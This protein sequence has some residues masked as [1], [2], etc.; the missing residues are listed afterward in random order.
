MMFTK[1]WSA[2]TAVE[3][4]DQMWTGRTEAMYSREQKRKA[5]ETLI[6]FD[7]SFADTIAELGYPCRTALRGWWRDYRRS[8]DASFDG[9]GREPRYSEEKRRLAVD[10]YLEHGR[11]LARTVRALGHPSNGPRRVDRRARAGPAEAAGPRKPAASMGTRVR[12][13]AELEARRGSAAE[14]AVDAH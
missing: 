4:L 1:K 7:M 2:E 5:I 6:R 13:V 3:I 10:Y 11:S 14:I 9:R 12:V 8:G